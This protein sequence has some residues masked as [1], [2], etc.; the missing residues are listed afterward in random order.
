[1]LHGADDL[2][3]PADNAPLLAARIPDSTV[4][5]HP[6]G[7]HGCFEEFAGEVTPLVLSFVS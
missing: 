1:M 3:V 7:R 5:L 4:H 2:M 6:R